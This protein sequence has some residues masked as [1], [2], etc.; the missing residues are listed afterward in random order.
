[1][2]RT[3]HGK[4]ILFV[5]VF[6]IIIPEIACLIE[7]DNE[8]EFFKFVESVELE[9]QKPVFETPGTLAFFINSDVLFT[10]R[11]RLVESDVR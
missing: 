8:D 5:K 3:K 6:R 10:C 11:K 1:M 9:G 4:G 2:R 7:F